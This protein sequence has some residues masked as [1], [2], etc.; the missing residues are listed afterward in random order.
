M[1]LQT[2][3][4]LLTGLACCSANIIDPRGPRPVE[5]GYKADK[6]ATQK[7]WGFCSD[8]DWGVKCPSG[9]KV[10]GLMDKHDHDMMKKID[11]IRTLLEKNQAHTSTTDRITKQTY[12]YLKEGLTST[13]GGDSSYYDL[14]QKLRRR[15]VDMKIKIDRQLIRMST[16]KD[17][18]R[19]QVTDIQRM[20]VDI[21]MKLR[22]CKGSCKTYTEF[23][24]D[25]ASY[26]T[27]D[28]QMDQLDTDASQSR[29]PSRP[30]SVMKSRPLKELA[31]VDEKYKSNPAGGGEQTRTLFSEVQAMQLTLE[32]E[33]SLTSPATVSKVPGTSSSSSSS[34]SSGSS[35]SSSTSSGTGSKGITE[36]SG[37]TG[38]FS[39]STSSCTRSIRTVVTHTATGP[40]ETRE[41]VIEGGPECR[42]ILESSRGGMGT[43]F[44]SL[45]GGLTSLTG[46]AKGS[47]MDSK[48]GFGDFDLGTFGMGAVEEDLPDV[49]ARSIKSSSVVQS[50]HAGKGTG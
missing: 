6:C 46:G 13:S 39:T 20:E 10:L 35:T 11:R 19:A 31:A 3:I 8:E 37:G 1:E 26:V 42:A 36:I 48:T 5:A 44:P 15:I 4:L 14:S 32:T 7:E 41:E 50:D 21:D 27:L 12:D 49:H 2:V 43:F 25:R 18:I 29:G 9:C 45:G 40:K 38:S 17:Q 23:S 24:V 34:G 30:L 16:M 22:A 47:L 33:G 28:K